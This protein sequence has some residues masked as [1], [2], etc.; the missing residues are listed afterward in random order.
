MNLTKTT[1][2]ARLR[3]MPPLRPKGPLLNRTRELAR[4]AASWQA[5]ARGSQFVA[6]EGRRRVGK[7]FL[8]GH[9]AGGRRGLFFGATRQSEAVELQRLYETVQRDM[10][11]QVAAL[12]GGGFQSWSAA[13][14]FFFAVAAK[15]PTAVVIDEIPYLTGSTPGFASILQY[16]WDHRPRDARLLLIV[17]GSAVSTMTALFGPRG[18]LRGRPTETLSVEPLSAYAARAFLPR[19]AP[20]KFIEAYAA[21]GGYPLHLEK[22]DPRRST[23]ANLLAL[24]GSSGGLLLDDASSMI[25]E[26]LAA[27]ST[28][29]QVL[30]EIGR[31]RSTF[32]QISSALQGKKIAY[33]LNLLERTGFIRKA[34]PLAAPKGA[35][36]HYEIG[37]A[38]L[39]FWHRVL[40][41]DVAL[42]EAGQGAAV[43]ARR[44][45]EWEKHVR[46]VFEEAARDHA[47]RLV[48][49]G[50]LPKDMLVGRWWRHDHGLDVEIDV[51]GIQGHQT[52]LIGGARWTSKPLPLAALT[53]LERMVAHVPNPA[54]QLTYALWTRSGVD[55]AIVQRGAR[56]FVVAD[57]L[58]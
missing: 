40:A 41:S 36:G 49:S 39:N 34:V 27:T 47:R 37:D 24:A 45:E 30:S 4:L 57:I 20:D 10:G 5:A 13:F 29:A 46:W 42:I 38:Y 2:G 44:R 23:D 26:E 21:C 19:L 56:S 48:A 54:Q 31:A 22:W 1:E 35:R 53:E 8:L 52:T 15:Q 18:S 28:H 11:P 32:S 25:Q 58:R 3:G 14:R 6:V 16:E 50:A 17:S 12:I 7:T 33:S 9:F 51:L 43:L 55:P